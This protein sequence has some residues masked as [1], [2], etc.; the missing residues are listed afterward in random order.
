M[1]KISDEATSSLRALRELYGD[2]LVTIEQLQDA[3]DLAV[4]NM[5]I[6][7]RNGGVAESAL[8]TPGR[9]IA[10]ASAMRMDNPRVRI[11]KAAYGIN[12]LKVMPG[13]IHKV[14]INR[15]GAVSAMLEGAVNLGLKPDEYEWEQYKG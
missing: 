8:M 7:A 1:S 2:A 3:L 12:G 10:L 4:L 11:I 14:S 15:Y 13:E 5:A 6:Y 9:M